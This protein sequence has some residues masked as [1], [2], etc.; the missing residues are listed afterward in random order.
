MFQWLSKNLPCIRAA[1][2]SL[3]PGKIKI[4]LAPV[5]FL[6]CLSCAF[7][8]LR[9]IGINTIPKN[10]W[11]L[12]P[13]GESPV[14]IRFDT[15]MDKAMVER[16]LQVYSPDGTADGELRWEGTALYFTPYVSW[17]PGIRYGLRLSGNVLARDGRETTL[18]IDIPFYAISR[19]SLPYVNSFCPPDG[20]SVGVSDEKILELN[21]SHPM[22]SRSTQEALRLDIPGEKFFE[23]LDDFK[24]LRIRSD[25]PLN[26]WTVYRWSIQEKAL[27][28]EGAPLAKEFSGRFTTDMDREFLE[29]VRVIP[30]I[31]PDA[32]FPTALSSGN[33][34]WGQWTPSALNLE[35]G[36]GFG[37]GI[38]VVFNKAPESESLRRAFS[39][40]PS[41]PGRVEM[42]S[43]FSAVFI[44][45]R[46]T[47]PETTYNLRISGTLRDSDGLRMGEDY[48]L[49]FT[50][51]IPYLRVISFSSTEGELI[52]VPQTDGAFSV[53]VTPGG[54]IKITIDFSL[55]FDPE[56]TALREESVFKISLR[57][58]FPLNLPLVRLRTARWIRS[59]KLQMEWE[60]LEA[61]RSGESHYYRLIIPGGSTGV[62]NGRGSYFKEDFI[63]HLEVEQ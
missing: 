2:C 4:A 9:P 60:G 25:R 44:P 3:R 14:I 6:L 38:G 41:L 31:P 8:D 61:G 5:F 22:D 32:Y 19:A 13:D 24:T 43:P 16:A 56:N 63:L 62:H 54:I 20:A 55:P 18:A 48:T 23:W 33:G 52:P 46:N 34:L 27:S 35:Q 36:L 30:L 50:T 37:H 47:E 21:F 53:S 59:D 39:F 49:A 11:A 12:L 51:D 15:K 28:M 42:L 7:V 45:A 17:K 57:P 1:S 26:P 58:F 40:S 29:V 10:P